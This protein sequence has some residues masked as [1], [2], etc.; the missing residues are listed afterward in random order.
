MNKRIGRTILAFVVALS[1]A[2]L[3]AAAGFAAVSKTIDASVSEAMPDCEH[4]HHKLPS[5]QTQKTADDGACM[6][7]CALNCFSFTA[8][9][10]SGIAFSSPASAA[11]KPVYASSIFASQM[12]SPPF[13]PPRA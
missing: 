5:D 9:T 12:G 8:T 2:M 6:A 10:F 4:H 11:L 13:R 3:P 1:V 7:A